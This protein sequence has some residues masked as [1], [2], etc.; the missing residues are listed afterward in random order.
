LYGNEQQKVAA[1][2]TKASEL[3]K[4][5]G[6]NLEEITPVVSVNATVEQKSSPHASQ[7]DPSHDVRKCFADNVILN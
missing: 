6:E 5:S 2:V 3:T 4:K 1:A 7:E